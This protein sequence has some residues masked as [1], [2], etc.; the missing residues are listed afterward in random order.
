MSSLFREISE[1]FYIHLLQP[2]NDAGFSI[3][4]EEIEGA[5]TPLHSGVL[6][7]GL[8]PAGAGG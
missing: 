4:A 8:L 1:L 6:E 7:G 3:I 5:L 2:P